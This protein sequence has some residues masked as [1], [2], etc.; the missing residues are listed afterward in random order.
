MARYIHND[1]RRQPAL[2]ASSYGDPALAAWRELLRDAAAPS[3][4]AQADDIP[5][6]LSLIGKRRGAGRGRA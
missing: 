3:N 2:D 1:Y 6:K 5:N 4:L